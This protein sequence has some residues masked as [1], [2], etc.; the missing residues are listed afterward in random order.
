MT[1]QHTDGPAKRGRRAD[2]A[3]EKREVVL[4]TRVT[5]AEARRI[6]RAAARLGIGPST[7]LRAAALDTDEDGRIPSSVKPAVEPAPAPLVS[8]ELND[9]R[10]QVKG[11]AANLNQMARIANTNRAVP[12]APTEDL[13]TVTEL[14]IETRD[15]CREVL[16]NLGAKGHG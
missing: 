3:P 4:T 5:D 6:K 13:P 7:L 14:M 8:P 16:T 12:L 2:A 1:D 15:L 9:L 10:V 11:A